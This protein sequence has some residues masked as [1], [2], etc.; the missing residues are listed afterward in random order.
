MEFNGYIWSLYRESQ[1][2][3][4]ALRKYSC[5]TKEFVIRDERILET[6][7]VST[8]DEEKVHEVDL[9]ELVGKFASRHQIS[10][11]EEASAF[12]QNTLLLDGLSFDMPADAKYDGDEEE[13]ENEVEDDKAGAKEVEASDDDSIEEE[14][15][16]DLTE[17]DWTFWH[18]YVEAISLGL[19][20]AHPDF[21]APFLFRRKFQSFQRISDQFGI[22]LPPVPGKGSKEAR[23]RY[24]GH[25]NH[26]LYEFRISCKFS[27]IE[28]C[29][30]LYDF[31]ANCCDISAVNDLPLPAKVWLLSGGTWDYDTLDNATKET[32]VPCWGGNLATRT[33]DILLMYCVAPR[34]YIHSIW[35]AVADGF[36]DP[37]SHYHG[38]VAVGCPIKTVPITFGELS[39]HELL[40]KKPEI[41]AKLQGA[42]GKPFTVPEYEAILEMMREKGQDLTEIPRIP[43]QEHMLDVDLLDERDVEIH[44]IEP[45][46]TR[47]GYSENDWVRQL[48]VKMGRGER[49]YPDYA[50]G[51]KTKRGEERAKMLVES[52]FQLSAH[53][54]FEDAYYQ[55]KS[56]ALRL[57][58]KTFILGAREGIWIFQYHRDDFE[59]KRFAARTW[60]ELT[61]PDIFHQVTTLIGKGAILGKPKPK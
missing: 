9:V 31:S 45:L 23:A 12:Y 59:I 20:L 37:F 41:R 21:F 56:Y 16:S 51:A 24:Y 54:Q 1:A 15:D 32:V 40:S 11:I 34:S 60:V 39:R 5:W 3:K 38:N 13:N 49:Y 2:G 43:L 61:D 42:G 19:H 22:P 47:L 48:P 46:L 7:Y 35:R 52:K 17:T 25:I 30:F 27:S 29:A 36:A 44:L 57:Q 55:A 53:R 6:P 28:L 26:A 8:N 58:S 4:E 10:T 18:D 50:V 33:G 14:S